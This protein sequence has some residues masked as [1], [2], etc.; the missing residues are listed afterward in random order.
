MKLLLGDEN[1]E[2]EVKQRRRLA[3]EK[4]VDTS[5]LDKMDE[6]TAF[7][8]CQEEALNETFNDDC[9]AWIKKYQAAKKKAAEDKQKEA[10]AAVEE[11]TKAKKVV[12]EKKEKETEAYTKEPEKKEGSK[13]T[14]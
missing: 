10:D 8:T 1:Q 12:F 9:K 11:E 13:T 4:E 14:Q 5:R 3:E 2:E 6:K 7:G